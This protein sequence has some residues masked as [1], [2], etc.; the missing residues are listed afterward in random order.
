MPITCRGLSF[1]YGH[2]QVFGDLSF[3]LPSCGLHAFYGRSG[4][5]KSTLAKILAGIETRWRADH[6]TLVPDT[7]YV[8]GGERLPSW[9]RIGEHLSTIPS[10][11]HPLTLAGQV[12]LNNALNQFP[13]TLSAGQQN[14]ANMVRYLTLPF[15][16]LILDEALANVDEPRRL[17]MLPFLRHVAGDRPVIYISHHTL[18]IATFCDVVYVLRSS[19]TGAATITRLRGLNVSNDGR[20]ALTRALTIVEQMLNVA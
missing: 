11:E 10:L 17:E 13:N 16:L 9:K 14:L 20:S 7:Y 4:A 12:G 18:E 5:G 6:L 8:H 15:K 2:R 3:E 19:L 1:S